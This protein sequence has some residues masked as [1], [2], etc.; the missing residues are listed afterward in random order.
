[1]AAFTHLQPCWL[2]GS[3]LSS[4]SMPGTGKKGIQVVMSWHATGR[5]LM[6][7]IMPSL[8]LT[9]ENMVR[10]MCLHH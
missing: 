1:M 10:A 7:G 8:V 3:F 9:S 5:E 2:R 6:F 4:H